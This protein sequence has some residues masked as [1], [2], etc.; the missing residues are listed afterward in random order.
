[1]TELYIITS[2]YCIS[3]SD[4]G[5]CNE[6]IK[7]DYCNTIDDTIEKLIEILKNIL[8]HLQPNSYY[9]FNFLKYN[10]NFNLM[11]KDFVIFYNN[12]LFS[13]YSEYY[14]NPGISIDIKIIKISD[15]LKYEQIL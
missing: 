12:L 4:D 8:Y 1:M 13:N 2:N 14:H 6:G 5:T 3:Y 7:L 11:Y 9:N 10:K 15:N